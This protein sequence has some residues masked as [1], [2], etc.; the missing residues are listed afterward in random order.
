[1]GGQRYKLSVVGGRGRLRNKIG[2][3]GGGVV[4]GSPTK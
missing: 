1:M 3:W 4:A 2:M